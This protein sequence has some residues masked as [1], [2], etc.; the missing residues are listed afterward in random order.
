MVPK[1]YQGKEGD[2]MI[3]M[4]MGVEIGLNP[5]QS[6]QNI[7][8]INGR[9]SI[10][11]DALLALVQKS[12][13]FDGIVETINE[14]TMTATCTIKR[15]GNPPHT[16]TF[17]KEDAEKASLWGKQG[18]WSQYPKRMLAMR[19]RGFALRNQFA[20]ALLGLITSEEAEDSPPIDITPC[21]ENIEEAHEQVTQSLEK[22]IY[23]DD[24]FDE[25][26]DG[27]K[28][29]IDSGKKTA[30]SMIQA[31]ETKFKLTDQQKEL[32]LALDNK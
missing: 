30:E 23:P 28:Q 26:F 31:I 12:P 7:A 22:P 11:G 27:F 25:K 17:S 32:I 21:A 18:P 6:L 2:T 9:P 20:D 4:M 10:Y 5:I 24:T 3:A 13:K 8:V 19:A 16:S 15:K 14:E 1:H 29:A